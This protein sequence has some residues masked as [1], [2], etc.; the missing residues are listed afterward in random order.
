M[1]LSLVFNGNISG[2]E[3]AGDERYGGYDGGERI[4]GLLVKYVCKP[5]NMV[6]QLVHQLKKQMQNNGLI[7]LQ[8]AM[9]CKILKVI[10]KICKG[11]IC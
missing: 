8:Q 3:E 10:K 9:L 7:N 5:W 11:N 6:V 4:E 2:D 1:A